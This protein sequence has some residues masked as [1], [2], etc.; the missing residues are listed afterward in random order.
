[1][2]RTELDLCRIIGCLMVL[3]IHVSAGVYNLL[4][5]ESAGFAMMNL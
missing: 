2:R 4:P 1:M 3:V 5:L